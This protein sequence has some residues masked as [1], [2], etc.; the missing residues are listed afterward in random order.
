MLRFLRFVGGALLGAI[1]GAGLVFMRAPRSG[2]RTRG[3]VRDRLQA[4]WS[5]GQRAADARRLELLAQL[6]EFKSPGR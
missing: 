3:M 5:E 2:A 6:E 1:V 4:V